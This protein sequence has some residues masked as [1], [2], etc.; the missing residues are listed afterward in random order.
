[1]YSFFTIFRVC[2]YDSFMCNTHFILYSHVPLHRDTSEQLKSFLKKPKQ[3]IVSLAIY[4]KYMGYCYIQNVAVKILKQSK[5][6]D[7]ISINVA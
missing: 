7:P 4:K 6:S 1:M 5:T 3:R 2:V